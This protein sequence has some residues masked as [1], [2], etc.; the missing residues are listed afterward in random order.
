MQNN[1]KTKTKSFRLA[2]LKK[3]HINT[4]LKNLFRK[5]RNNLSKLYG[6]RLVLCELLVYLSS[7]F[8]NVIPFDTVG[9]LIK[10]LVHVH[11]NAS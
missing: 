1:L 11:L 2:Y 7:C 5:W 10:I 6:G 8:H 3:K 4:I 9:F